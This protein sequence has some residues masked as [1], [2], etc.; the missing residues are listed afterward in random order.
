MALI[1][2]DGSSLEDADSYISVSDADAYHSKRGATLWSALTVD[3]KEQALRRATEYMVGEYRD[4]WLGRR[5]K[6]VQGL[7]WPRVGVI[8]PDLADMACIPST[9]VPKDVRIACASLALRAAAGEL[10]ED[11]EQRVVRETIGP[12]TTEW[13]SDSSPKRKY[14][15]V[16]SMLKMYMSGGGNSMMATL[17]RC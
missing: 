5:A 16:D 13:D 10:V 2:E 14:P 7:D 6:A 17:V 3:E 4:R 1:V 8:I 11:I 12:I 9:F 15:Q